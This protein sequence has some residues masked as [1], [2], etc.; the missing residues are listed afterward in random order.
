MDKLLDFI[1]RNKVGIIAT[2]IVH[3]AIFVYFQVATYKEA[4]LFEPWNFISA[5]NEAPDDIEISPDQ[6]ETTEEQFL[7]DT[8]K[9]VSSF[10]R[11]ENDGREQSREDNIHYTSYAQG[12]NSEEIERNYEQQL[13][14][15][16]R[17][18]REERED[19]KASN[20]PDLDVREEKT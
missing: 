2:L 8:Q 16:I 13:K 20:E 19:G 7:F 10:V 1:E 11:D 4:V 9:E 3:V 12:G 6:I 14:D 18:Q 17:R 15:E 5:K